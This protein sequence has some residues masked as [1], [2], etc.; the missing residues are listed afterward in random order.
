MDIEELIKIGKYL[1]E[2]NKPEWALII[3]RIIMDEIEVAME[4]DNIDYSDDEGDAVDEGVPDV[5]VDERG[6]HS[7]I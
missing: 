4:D 5:R 1:E 3:Q 6:F 7:L 2:K